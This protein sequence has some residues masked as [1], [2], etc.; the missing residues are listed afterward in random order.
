MAQD[1]GDGP[2][3]KRRKCWLCLF[4]AARSFCARSALFA[5]PIKLSSAAGDRA[6][7]ARVDASRETSAPPANTCGRHLGVH[8][9]SRGGAPG[10][11]PH[12]R[13]P[14]AFRQITSRP[15]RAP[16]ASG[17]Y[18]RVLAALASRA[19]NS[20]TIPSCRDSVATHNTHHCHGLQGLG[21]LGL[22]PGGGGVARPP[23]QRAKM[24]TS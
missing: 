22:M 2:A 5:R 7:S 8:H 23:G 4:F 13:S 24:Q 15:G 11:D 10:A 19:P 6:N 3:Q 9:F 1:F 21:L 17:T 16:G 18:L 20:C 12:P 14:S